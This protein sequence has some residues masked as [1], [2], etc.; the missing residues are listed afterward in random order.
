M[1]HFPVSGR[2]NVLRWGVA[3]AAVS[4]LFALSA[5]GTPVVADGGL[6][7]RADAVLR[8]GEPN[9]V[10][11]QLDPNTVTT[12][13]TLAALV[14]SRN[15]GFVYLYQVGTDGRTLDL[16]FPNE[17]DQQNSVDG[18]HPMSLPRPTWRLRAR[19]PAGIGYLIAVVSEEPQAFS[20]LS[21]AAGDGRFQI[22]GRYAATMVQL[23]ERASR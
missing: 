12:G 10:K 16:V 18:D 14:Q 15:A 23:T 21:K 1:K 17:I 7:A 19:G 5:C 13:D 6:L 2:R 8:G 20:S 4:S 3:L 22:E 9:V 11:L